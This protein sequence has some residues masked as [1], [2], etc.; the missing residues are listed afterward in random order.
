MAENYGKADMTLHVYGTG[1]TEFLD[2]PPREPPT[3][4]KYVCHHPYE[5]GHNGAGARPPAQMMVCDCGRNAICPVCGYGFGSLPCDCD[6]I[7]VKREP[8]WTPDAP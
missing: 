2:L 5:Y 1:A 8:G 3:N 6:G 4:S 7:M